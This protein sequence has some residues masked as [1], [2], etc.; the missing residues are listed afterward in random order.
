V[1]ETHAKQ[2]HLCA[3]LLNDLNRDARV[4]RIAGSRRSRSSLASTVNPR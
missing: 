2:R 4:V 3:E 1:A